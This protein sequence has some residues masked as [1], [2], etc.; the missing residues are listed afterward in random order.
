MVEQTGGLRLDSFAGAT[1]DRNGRQAI[2]PGDHAE[3]WMMKRAN[4]A[5]EA[6][7]MPPPSSNVEP[8]S[9]YQIAILQKWIDQGAQY[10]KHWAF[11]PPIRHE[12][13]TPSN[14]DWVLNP[15][16]TFVLSGLENAGLNP[17]PMAT[18]ER[19]IRRVALTLT[20][21]PP[22]P[23]EVAEYTEDESPNAHIKM[24]DRYLESP[25]YGEHMA[26]YWLDA[27][28]YG[29]THGLHLDNYREVYPYRD[30]V[31]RA[32]N[33]DLPYDEF[34][35]WQL[36]GDLLPDPSLDQLV[37]SGYVR[38]HPST[39]E[40]GAIEKEFLVKNTADRVDT[41]STVFLGLTMACARCHD[42][43]YDP[44]SHEDYYEFF[45]YFNST[46]DPVLD[47]NSAVHPPIIKAPSPEQ[48]ARDKELQAELKNLQAQVPDQEA[49]KW[50]DGIVA[51]V[52][53]V[54]TWEKTKEAYQ[55][56][57][58]ETAVKTVHPPEDPE[59]ADSV[60][61]E[62]T[63]LKD[64]ARVNNIVGKS[65]AAGYVRAT[66][67]A[68]VETEYTFRFGADDAIKIWLNGELVH[69]DPE[70]GGLV[71][72][73]EVVKV[74]LK[75]GDNQLLVKVINGGGPDGVQVTYG[76]DVFQLVQS[77]LDE[78]GQF[79][80]TGEG[81]AEAKSLYLRIGVDNDLATTYKATY[82]EHQDLL[83][84]IPTTLIAQEMEEPRPSF[85]LHRGEYDQEREQVGRETIDVLNPLPTG[86]PNNRLGL[87]DWMLSEENPLV[88]RVYVNR[89]WQMVFG[90]GIVETSEDFGSQGSWPSHPELLDW[91]SV[92]FRENGWSN[93]DLLRMILTSATF[94]QSS[95]T[96]DKKQ[97]ID[98]ENALLSRGP[99]F[100]LDAEVIRD[101]ALYVAG[102]M[103]PKMGG[104]GFRPYQPGGLWEAVAYQGSNTDTYVKDETDA[105][106]RRSVYMFWKR[107]SPP[108][109]MA[110]F[111]APTREA[112]VVRRAATNTPMQA[113]ATMNETAFVES[114]RHMA[115]RIMGHQGNTAQR[116]DF[117]YRLLFS[118][119]PTAQEAKVVADFYNS[120]VTKYRSSEEEAVKL[121]SVGDSGRNESLDTS[122]H[123]AWTLVCNLLLNLDE[124]L[125]IN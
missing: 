44:L 20:G 27:V 125:T 119:A 73:S 117:A 9:K 80:S 21:L 108:P 15:I 11:I 18:K 67:T 98:P 106:Y 116:I 63:S 59:K 103:N 5:V 90:T 49:K 42:H 64:R 36:A 114:A 91:L 47:G 112:C 74:T 38:M 89:V 85:I 107:T 105:I 35:R 78:N 52:P 115:E 1:E 87:A 3:S 123:A 58:F 8:L 32:Y 111:D 56:V 95:M 109:V 55:E 79:K 113:L 104:P 6:L 75:K 53:K 51:R 22:T 17:A 76:D 72:N 84:S 23:E 39:N 100:R 88:T 29:D 2:V 124:A 46:K 82:K 68:P 40:G 71:V 45:A 14:K 69:E 97:R 50:I 121:L 101:Q 83:A 93:K 118:R 54:S 70:L 26:R 16:D 92:E 96:S 4:P 60:D 48:Q 102:I 77:S 66:V 24:V 25:K 81:L 65:N 57:N 37:A 120:Q 94:Q 122:E 43:K 33:D 10:D 41:T 19:L 34:L 28:R 99:R 31:V 62:P 61:W 110:I 30:W 86:S 13:P 12:L 7:R